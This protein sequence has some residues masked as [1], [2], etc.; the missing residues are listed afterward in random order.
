MEGGEKGVGMT[1]RLI[2]CHLS[3]NGGLNINVPPRLS[4]KI[5]GVQPAWLREMEL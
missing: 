5:N 2:I 4:G 3:S 1:L